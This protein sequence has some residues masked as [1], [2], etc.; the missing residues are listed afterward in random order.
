MNRNV[1][2]AALLVS[3]VSRPVFGA[4]VLID[5]NYFQ[6]GQA[7]TAPGA[8]L[9]VETLVQT[10]TTDQGVP[11]W[12]AFNAGPVYSYD[13]GQNC[14]F[15]A[16]PCAVDG[17]S[18]FAPSLNPTTPAG[19][20]PGMFWT[21]GNANEPIDCLISCA[22]LDSEPVVM[23]RIDFDQPTNFVNVLGYNQG[24]DPLAVMAFNAAGNALGGAYVTAGGSGFGWGDATIL[25]DQPDISAIL[26]AGLDNTYRPINDIE[27]NQRT[28]VPLPDE[29]WLFLSSVPLALLFHWRRPRPVRVRPSRG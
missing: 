21:T 8:T 26:V 12:E 3:L 1:A 14:M 17:H 16:T 22:F 6:P 28:S 7:I 15:G 20:G 2:I 10:G 29:M 27:Y 11:M 18:V 25:D 4:I 24:G 5:P 9:S 23:L 19:F 13:V